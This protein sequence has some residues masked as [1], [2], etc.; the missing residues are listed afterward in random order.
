MGRGVQDVY[1]GHAKRLVL[2]YSQ[3]IEKEASYETRSFFD[4][5]RDV[6]GFG[7]GGHDPRAR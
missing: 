2:H 7:F 1:S 4:A 3:P 5:F 6:S